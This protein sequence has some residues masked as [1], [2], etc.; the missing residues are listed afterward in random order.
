MRFLGGFIVGLALACSLSA[1]EVPD[2][3]IGM[4]VT[5][6]L[7]TGDKISGLLLGR[8]QRDTTDAIRVRTEIGTATIDLGQI[9]ELRLLED[10][11]RHAW[12]LLL[13]P[14]A[15]PIGANSSAVSLE[16]MTIG[17]AIGIGDVGS[18]LVLRSI[19]PGIPSSHQL[20]VINAKA[21]L[22][23]AEY[24][25]LDG[26][27]SVAAG[28]N[29][30]WVNS[31]NQLQHLWVAATFTRVRSRL[32]L[33][34]FYN[35]SNRDVY[36]VAAGTFGSVAMRYARNAIGF[37]V[38]LDVQM[39]ARDDLHVLAE[40]WN[41]DL[42]RPYQSMVVVGVRLANTALAL[43]AGLAITSQVMLPLAAVSW[44]PW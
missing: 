22:L 11:Y 20:S 16:L 9:A 21:T 3:W 35:L 23:R 42:A 27:L 26:Y 25:Q 37:G 15:E 17:A 18:L 32:T 31:P 6:R 7:T 13:M 29:L 41:S 44:T 4:P 10:L 43:D 38:G 40:L 12:R 1:T 39:P 24:Q 30:A 2:E 36:E 14:T 28:G 19:V 34:T 5:V 8:V 33:M